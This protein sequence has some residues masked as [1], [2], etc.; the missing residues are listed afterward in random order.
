MVYNG[1]VMKTMSGDMEIKDRLISEYQLLR[2]IRTAAEKE[3]TAETV[4]IIDEE[5]RYIKLKLQPLE[6]PDD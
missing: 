5:I 2:R 3:G 6:L 1:M 4:R